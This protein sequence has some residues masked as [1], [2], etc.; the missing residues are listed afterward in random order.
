MAGCGPPLLLVCATWANHL[1]GEL[2]RA[3]RL[4]VDTGL[5]AKKWT[6]QQVVDVFHAHTAEDD[7]EVQNDTNRYIVWPG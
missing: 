5:H 7:V 6:R 4:V 2:L 1:E 3:I